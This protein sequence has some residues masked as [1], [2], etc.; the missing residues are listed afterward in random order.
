MSII[1]ANCSINRNGEEAVVKS[2]WR[3]LS[4]VLQQLFLLF[5]NLLKYFAANALTY[6]IIKLKR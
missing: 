1:A 2:R 4:L 6:Y 3:I 5:D